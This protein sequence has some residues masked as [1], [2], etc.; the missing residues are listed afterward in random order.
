M[1]HWIVLLRPKQA[2]LGALVIAAKGP[3]TALPD[4]PEEAFLELRTVTRRVER[5]LDEA[6]AFDRMNYLMLMMVDPHVHF[7]ALPR[8]AQ[9][10][11]FADTTFTDPGWPGPPKIDSA[12]ALTEEILALIRDQLRAAWDG[13]RD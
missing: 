4:L 3:A 8:Y 10:R 13:T 9:K 11:V 7:H 12:P 1:D 2:T 5:A 6:F